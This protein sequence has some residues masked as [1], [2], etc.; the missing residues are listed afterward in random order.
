MG[1]NKL[2]CEVAERQ[3]KVLDQVLAKLKDN[4][5]GTQLE[6]SRLQAA[7]VWLNFNESLGPLERLTG[8]HVHTKVPSKVALKDL[9]M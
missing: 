4:G 6:R 3:L 7:K 8:P 1:P 9:N 2:V 5:L